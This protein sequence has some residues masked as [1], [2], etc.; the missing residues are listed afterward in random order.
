MR[1]CKLQLDMVKAA[2]TMFANFV[3]VPYL[4]RSGPLTPKESNRSN[5]N[6]PVKPAKPIL[7]L[8]LCAVT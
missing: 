1:T 2:L 8:Q 7:T 3:D 6:E 5:S 4:R